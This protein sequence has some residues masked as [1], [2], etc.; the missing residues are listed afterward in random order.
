MTETAALPDKS[1][2]ELREAL[3][4]AFARVAAGN[5][6]HARVLEII[7]GR[8]AVVLQQLDFLRKL[9]TTELPD[10]Y[11]TSGVWLI[12]DT[13]SVDVATLA[14]ALQGAQQKQQQDHNLQHG[15]VH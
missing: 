13:V 3:A 10:W 8:L 15:A 9:S 14:A 11:R 5:P 2:D 1:S 7:A 12:A 6:A 4:D